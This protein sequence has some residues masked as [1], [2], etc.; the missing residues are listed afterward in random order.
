M[1]GVQLKE[2]FNKY[3]IIFDINNDNILAFCGNIA[4]AYNLF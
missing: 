1:F 2:I 3:P 4:L